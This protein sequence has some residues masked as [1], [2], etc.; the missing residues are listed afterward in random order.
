[1]HVKHI[2]PILA[3]FLLLLPFAAFAQSTDGSISGIVADNTGAVL[4]GATVTATNIGALVERDPGSPVLERYARLGRLLGGLPE[5]TGGAEAR[6][7]LVVTLSEWTA[8]LGVQRL[9]AFGIGEAAIPAIVADSRGSSMRT[10]PIV[11]TDEEIAGIL[12]ATI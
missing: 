5:A 11:L 4:P 7:G 1:M 2:R 3:L 6:A 8:L 12:A 10:N 9:R